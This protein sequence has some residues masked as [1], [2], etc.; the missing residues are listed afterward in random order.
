MKG[1]GAGK[2][3][4]QDGERKG[5]PHTQPVRVVPKALGAGGPPNNPFALGNRGWG[6]ALLSLK[7]AL[8]PTSR[9]PQKEE[10]K[11]HKTP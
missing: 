2:D 8:Q 11:L 7:W 6:R 4:S 1:E 9:H 10:S 3:S 5:S